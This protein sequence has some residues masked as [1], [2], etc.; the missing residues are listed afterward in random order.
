MAPVFSSLYS[1]EEAKHLCQVKTLKVYEERTASFCDSSGKN[2]F[3]NHLL[4]SMVLLPRVL[5]QDGLIHACKKQGLTLLNLKQ[6][7]PGQRL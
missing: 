2:E 1:F 4:A 7:L 5:L 6:I 3:F